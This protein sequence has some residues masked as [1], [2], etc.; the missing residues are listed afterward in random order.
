MTDTILAHR[1]LIERRE[2]VHAS[3]D[4]IDTKGRRFG[5]RV[6][7]EVLEYVPAED[8]ANWGYRIAPDM[9][10][11][12]FHALPHA[13]RDGVDYGAWQS[14]K[15]CRTEADAHAYA[16]KYLADAEKRALKNKARAA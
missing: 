6:R 12:R 13:T 15:L 9:L 1:K 4:A 7:I 8:G 14:G 10:G 16:A 2:P 5:A 3:F 11:I